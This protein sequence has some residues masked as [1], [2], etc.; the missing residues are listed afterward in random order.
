MNPRI[1]L[2]F[3]LVSVFFSDVKAQDPQFTQFYANPMYLNPAFA[4]TARCP[5]ICMNYMLHIP[6][7][8]T[9]TLTL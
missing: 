5:R 3:L 7:V 6:E 2:P 8:S 4:G 1:L 9:C